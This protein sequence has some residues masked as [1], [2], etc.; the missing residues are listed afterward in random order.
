MQKNNHKEGT[1]KSSERNVVQRFKIDQGR[2]ERSMEQRLA[3]LEHNARQSRL[4]MEAD[5]P[6][7]TKTRERTEGAAKAV[8]A[9]HGDSCVA[10]RV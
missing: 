9:K 4:A 5:G 1:T 2:F 10:Q 7:N 8:Q 6:A 3:R